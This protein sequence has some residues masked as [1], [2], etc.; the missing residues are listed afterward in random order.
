MFGHKLFAELVSFKT[1]FSV[2]SVGMC[3]VSLDVLMRVT[4]SHQ[5]LPRY[6]VTRFTGSSGFIGI[7]TILMGYWRSTNIFAW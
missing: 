7:V 5:K 3:P 1:V 2:S 6:F 4:L